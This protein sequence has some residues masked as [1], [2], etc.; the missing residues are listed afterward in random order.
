MIKALLFS[1]FIT[2]PTNDTNKNVYGIDI[3]HYQGDIVSK[4]KESDNIT[5]VICKAT[6]G[7]TYTDPDFES[8]WKALSDRNI[9]KGAYHFYISSDSPEKQAAHFI[10]TASKPDIQP[11]LDIE[12]LGIKAPITPEVLQADLLVF[13][14][15]IEKSYNRIP[16]IYTNP[17]FA[18][19]Y[20]TKSEFSKYPLWIADYAKKSEPYVPTVWKDKGWTIW[21]KSESYTVESDTSDFDIFNGNL[22]KFK[23]FISN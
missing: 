3:S 6:E 23:Q 15:L 16:I 1:L 14:N 22:D 2:S 13:L 5:F 20:I 7:I 17:Y 18:N 11:I 10:Q 12:T 21:Q 9:I 4:L 19:E 8:N